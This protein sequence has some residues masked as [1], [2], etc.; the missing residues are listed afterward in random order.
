MRVEVNHIEEHPAVSPRSR[1][2]EIL[3]AVEFLL[4]ETAAARRLALQYSSD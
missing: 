2:P 3:D 1:I 4:T